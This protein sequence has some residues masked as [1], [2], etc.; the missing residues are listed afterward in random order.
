MNL[1]TSLKVFSVWKKM[2]TLAKLNEGFQLRRT[3]RL[4]QGSMNSWMRQYDLKMEEKEAEEE[5]RRA[6]KNAGI[7]HDE[8]VVRKSFTAMVWNL[9]SHR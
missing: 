2:K 4:L 5:E 1:K 7:Y 3:R 9:I 8:K 6:L